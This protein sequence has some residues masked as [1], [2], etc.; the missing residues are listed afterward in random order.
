MPRG[1]EEPVW[2]PT[3]ELVYREGNRWMSVAPPSA[4][5]ARP[6]A[7]TFLFSG[8]YLNVLGRSHD[9]AADGRHLLIAGPAEATS[10]SLT[11]VTNWVTKLPARTSDR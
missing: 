3:G 10:T 9:I 2:S 7:A 6:G 8:P 5:S 11:V 1:G 4:P